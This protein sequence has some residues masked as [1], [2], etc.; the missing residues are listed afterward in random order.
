MAAKATLIYI[1]H[2][3]GAFQA[4]FGVTLTG[5]FASNGD[6]LDLSQLGVQS[7]SA[8]VCVE[9]IEITP[10]PGPLKG[11]TWLY[12][13]GTSQANGLLEAFNGTTQ[14][15]ASGNTYASLS[16]GATFTLMGIATFVP[17]R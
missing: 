16:L 4:Y 9:F 12:V 2:T 1:D 17:F 5:S 15:T 10:A 7:N 6:T 3:K 14:L 11:A 8:P 13:P